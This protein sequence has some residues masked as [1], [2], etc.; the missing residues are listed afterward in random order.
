MSLRLKS[1]F[2]GFASPAKQGGLAPLSQAELYRQVSRA[3][4]DPVAEIERRG[5][6]PLTPFP[7]ERDHDG[8]EVDLDGFELQWSLMA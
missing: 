3:T 8:V 7:V 5:F 6:V 1:A 2:D 4:G